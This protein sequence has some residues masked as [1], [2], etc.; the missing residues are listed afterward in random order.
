MKIH[1][2][3]PAY[4]FLKGFLPSR[5]FRILS[6]SGMAALLLLY[7]SMAH[8][9]FIISADIK[10]V[11][12]KNF[13]KE[14]INL[15]DTMDFS[16]LSPS[17]HL[18]LLPQLRK[19]EDAGMFGA[20]APDPKAFPVRVIT[21]PS[22]FPWSNLITRASARYKIPSELI[23]AVIHSESAFNTDAVSPKGAMGAMQIMPETAKHLGL[24]NP[25]DAEENVMKGCAYLHRMMA[26]YNSLEL[27]LAAYHAGPGTV[28]RYEG[29]PPYASTQ[30]YIQ[31]VLSLAEH[32]RENGLSKLDGKTK[33]P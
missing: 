23:A 24:E 12:K 13:P 26:K 11:E 31:R 15:M 10:V 20:A 6:F 22:Q 7:A 33:K 29:I 1:I 32:Y 9:G 17:A 5:L 27:A 30:N 18:L 3:R 25:F 16:S 2:L 19:G 4:F 14:D 21:P 28:D 8:A